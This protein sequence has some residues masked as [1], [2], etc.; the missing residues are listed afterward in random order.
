MY[1]KEDVKAKLAK[2]NVIIEE[3][4]KFKEQLEHAAAEA[5]LKR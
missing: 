3:L 5:G 4:S 2:I 1:K